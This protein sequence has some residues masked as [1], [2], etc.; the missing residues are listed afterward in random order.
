MGTSKSY[1]APTSP[2]WR[3]AKLRFGRFAAQGGN[4]GGGVAGV[5]DAYVRAHGGATAAAS[6]AVAAKATL[7]RLGSFFGDVARLG[8]EGALRENGLGNLMGLGTE[9][10]LLGIADLVC[11][12]GATHDQADARHAAVEVLNKMLDDAATED[13]LALLF[14]SNANSAGV[15]D[16]FEQF[17]VQFV[18]G[19]MLRVLG[20]GLES[21]PVDAG[22][23]RLRS[24]EILDYV[25]SRVNLEM[26]LFSDVAVLDFGGERGREL[27]DRVFQDAY[28]VCVL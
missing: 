4:A 17:V 13:E 15:R 28:E 24:K 14:E 2:A 1:E 9:A 10:V 22:T 3:R 21:G 16:L 26:A 25:A 23:K 11:P 18:Y 6:S 27:V 5:V 12:D 19:K 8:F 20:E 7:R